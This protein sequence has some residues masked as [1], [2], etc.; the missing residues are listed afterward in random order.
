MSLLTTPIHELLDGLFVD[1]RPRIEIAGLCLVRFPEA[2]PVLRALLER[3]AD[4]QLEPEE[5]DTF[6]VGLHILAAGRDPL[7]FKPFLRLLRLPPD[8]QE[9]LLGDAVTELTSYAAAGMFDGDVEGLMGMI[10]DP[11]LDDL[12]RGDLLGAL[13][14]LTWDKRI[15]LDR[16]AAFLKRFDDERLA[17]AGE[18]VWSEWE[19]S[20]SLLGLQALAPRVEAAFS[21]GRIDKTVG[22]LDMFRLTLAE[23]K[24]APD[25]IERFRSRHRGYIEDLAVA[26]EG[27]SWGEDA[28]ADRWNGD[29]WPAVV[30]ALNP[31]RGVGRN[32][33]CPCGSGKK[34]KKC[35][36]DRAG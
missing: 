3:A 14:F 33:P 21:D 35:C 12:I 7:S 32:D 30:P 4:G 25:D 23:A 18:F 20:I 28:E 31:W 15:D 1:G 11:D 6:F 9:W 34:F 17:V 36:L 26:L 16:T 10:V 27:Y 5:K 24:A 29:V 19:Q 13:A 22:D 2:A 8:E